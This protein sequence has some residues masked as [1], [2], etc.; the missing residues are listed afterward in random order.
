MRLG[1]S[2]DLQGVDDARNETE[3]RQQDVDEEVCIATSLKENT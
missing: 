1:S 3:D 2:C